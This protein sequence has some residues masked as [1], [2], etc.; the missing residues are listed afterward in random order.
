MKRL[1][2][3]FTVVV[4]VCFGVANAATNLTLDT[5]LKRSDQTAIIV[6]WDVVS[7]NHPLQSDLFQKN[8][9]Q[10]QKD[11]TKKVLNKLKVKHLKKRQ[12]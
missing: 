4:L 2:Q 12:K 7:L 3:T 9:K 11:F 10:Y 5:K 8:F 6:I 1:L